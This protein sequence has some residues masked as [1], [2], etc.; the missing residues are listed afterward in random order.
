[1]FG[2]PPLPTLMSGL[3]GIPSISTH[4]GPAQQEIRESK[5]CRATSR[6]PCRTGRAVLVPKQV[7]EVGSQCMPYAFLG[8]TGDQLSAQFEAQQLAGVEHFAIPPIAPP[9]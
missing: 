3:A 4:T 2:H 6:L 8:L 9:V 1:M 7:R 5:R